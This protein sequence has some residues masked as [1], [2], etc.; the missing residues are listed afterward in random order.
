MNRN[1]EFKVGD[2]V[3]RTGGAH[4][5]TAEGAYITVEWVGDD[6]YFGG[7]GANGNRRMLNKGF[8]WELYVERKTWTVTTEHRVPEAFERF[9]VPADGP[10]RSKPQVMLQSTTGR[11]YDVIVSIEEAS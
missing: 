9:I 7:L 11:T 4:G 3:T 5:Q 2:K 8:R 10:F 1:F 6:T